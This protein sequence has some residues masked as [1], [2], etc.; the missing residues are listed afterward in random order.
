[1]THADIYEKF[2]IEYDK[3]N[4]TTSYPSLTDYEI[5]TLLDKAYLALIAQKFTGN[6]IRKMPFEGDEKAVEDLQQLVTYIQEDLNGPGSV[7]TNMYSVVPFDK[8]QMLYVVNVYLI[9]TTIGQLEP[10]KMQAYAKQ[11]TSLQFNKF[12]SSINNKPWTKHPVYC[13]TDKSIMIAAG[14]DFINGTGQQII[15]A[16][17]IVEYI[18]MPKKFAD[19][20]KPIQEQN[21]IEFELSDTMAEELINL[22]LVMSM[23]TVESPRMQ[24]KA[25]LRGFES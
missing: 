19:K 16:S 20:N 22:A 7:Q 6:N 3:E 13:I 25:Q 9:N 12:L 14:N 15:F 4:V 2:M 23:E 17:A 18:K 1:M 21:D 11:V 5:A 10:I 8:N 24:T